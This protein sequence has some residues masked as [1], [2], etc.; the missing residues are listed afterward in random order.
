MIKNYLLIIAIFFLYSCES[1]NNSDRVK[2]RYSNVESL[3]DLIDQKNITEEESSIEDAINGDLARKV[4]LKNDKYQGYYKVGKPYK[5][6][7]ITYTPKNFANLEQTGVASWYGDAFHGKKTANGEIYNK[8][9]MT[10]AHR[11]LPMPSLV[12]VTNLANNKHVI[13]RVSDRGPFAKNRIIDLSQ[14][15]AEVLEY[16]NKGVTA[17][18]VEL[19]KEETEE[20]LIELGLK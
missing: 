5:I 12:K 3:N 16:K 9:D 13:V 4:K 10:A 7:G 6:Y 19:L 8:G 18:K 20:F 14:R 15:A 1:L 17:V 11:T 2:S